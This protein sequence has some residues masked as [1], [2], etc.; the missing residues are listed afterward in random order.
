MYSHPP[1]L[2]SRLL[3]GKEVWLNIQDCERKEIW[4]QSTITQNRGTGCEMLDV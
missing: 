1:E 3:Q 2:S 4:K